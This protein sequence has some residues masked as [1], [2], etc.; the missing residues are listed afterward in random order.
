MPSARLLWCAAESADVSRCECDA[1][2]GYEIEPLRK[3]A[4]PVNQ[5]DGRWRDMLP[6]VI[7]VANRA[8]S[9]HNTQPWLWRSLPDG[10]RLFADDSRW[11]SATD[12]DHHGQIVSCG[13]ALRLAATAA[14]SV[15]FAT[16]ITYG[17]KGADPLA[18]IQGSYAE[19]APESAVEI[20]KAAQQRISDRRAV[21]RCAGEQRAP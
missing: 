4:I 18:T 9:L 16:E 17:R 2:Y 8:P 5:S 3:G 19:T 14:Q 7:H 20:V 6:Y 10:V 11:L 1:T 15:G 12:P 21:G 13:A